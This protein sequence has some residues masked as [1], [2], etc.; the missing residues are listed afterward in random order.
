MKDII[1]NILNILTIFLS[2]VP[3][4]KISYIFKAYNLFMQDIWKILTWWAQID[5][6][7][8]E[9]LGQSCLPGWV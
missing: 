7:R 9:Q 2:S 4:Y 1:F 3:E 8:K 6:S 5:S